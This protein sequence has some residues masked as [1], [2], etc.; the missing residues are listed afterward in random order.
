[1]K[2]GLD[3]DLRFMKRKKNNPCD[4]P[5]NLH[6]QHRENLVCYSMSTKEA[7]TCTKALP[8]SFLTWEE[9]CL[10]QQEHLQILLLSRASENSLAEHHLHRRCYCQ[11]PS[12]SWGI[13]HLFVELHHHRRYY[14]QYQC[15]PRGLAHLSVEPHHL[16][17]HSQ[18]FPSGSP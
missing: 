6:S 1:M 3:L 12:G 9:E 15:R 11:S 8:S 10:L 13:A 7:K 4:L 16:P 14:R 18:Q 17:K 2:K 5:L